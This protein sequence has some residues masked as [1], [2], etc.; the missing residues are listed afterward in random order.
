MNALGRAVAAEVVRVFS[1]RTWWVLAVVL[2]IYVAVT[3]GGFAFFVTT[4]TEGGPGPLPAEV[5]TQ[6]VYSSTT[7]VALVIPLLFGAL[8]ATSEY[9]WRTLTPTFL[10]QPRRSVV[11]IGRLV[12]ALVVGALYGI[13]GAATSVA[14]GAGVLAANG[15][16][17]LLADPEVWG[18]IART[19]LACALWSL[20]GLGLGALLTS[21][22]AAIVIVLVFTQFVEPL[23]R[24]VAG[25]WEWS[26]EI[27]R[28][29]PGAATDSLV[30]A[31]I[32]ASIGELDPTV[33]GVIEPL[34]RLEGGVVL[35]S[36]SVALI[37]I[38]AVT[39][40]RRDVE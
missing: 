21:Q 18:L 36:L 25:A 6:L 32:I 31:G 5:A 4:E 35:A 27:A 8:A 7:S 1:L 9:R 15:V 24:I 34:T 29:L 40:L 14:A 17:T 33:P 37:A 28:Y 26:A 11:L 3:A 22:I 16:D 12:V 38:A 13:V 20:L 10:A 19:V 2:I 23:L 39:T 30:G